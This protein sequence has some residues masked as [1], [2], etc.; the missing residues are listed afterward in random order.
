MVRRDRRRNHGLV[1]TAIRIL[2]AFACLLLV[3]VAL[4]FAFVALLMTGGDSAFPDESGWVYAPLAISLALTTAAISTTA[5]GYV[6]AS[7]ALIAASC[8]AYAATWI[9]WSPTG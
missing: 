7:A 6:A 8:L 2:E 9:Y 1:T 4:G 3:V 5:L